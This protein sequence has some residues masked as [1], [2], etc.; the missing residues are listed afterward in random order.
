MVS[1][2]S[3]GNRIDCTNVPDIRLAY[4]EET[5][6]EEL[7]FLRHVLMASEDDNDSSLLPTITG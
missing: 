5:L 6:T 2:Y 1:T 4:R 3:S 7:K